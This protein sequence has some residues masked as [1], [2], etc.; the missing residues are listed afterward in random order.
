MV[1]GRIQSFIFSVNGEA[2]GGADKSNENVQHRHEIP[3]EKN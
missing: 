2:E 1:H 3:I